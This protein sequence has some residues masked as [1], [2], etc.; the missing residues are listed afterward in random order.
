MAE[1]IK[2]STNPKK[3]KLWILTELYYPENN[4][5]GY[6]MTRIGEGLTKNFDVKV[7][8]GQPNYAF[9]GTI[10]PKNENH[11]DVEIF[12]V[13]GTTL[14]KNVL[15]FRLIN[16]ITHGWSVFFNA[17]FKIKKSDEVLTVSAPPSL[18]FL[19]A[20]AAKIKS[21]E[22]SVIIHDKYPE[23]LIA[24]KKTKPDS[25]FIKFFNRLNRWLYSNAKKIIVVGRDMEDI[26]R[27]QLKETV[28]P[29]N[30][31]AV[32][33]NWAALEE[34]EPRLKNENELLNKLGIADKF[35]FLYA[36]NMGHPQ[37]VESIIEC[38][39]KLKDHEDIRFIF[40]G[41]GVKRKW[42]EAEIEKNNLTNVFLL[43]PLPREK[44]TD[45]L[46]AC[47]V[48]FVSL[49]KKM[50]GVAMPSRTYNFLAAGKPILALTEKN[51][52]VERIISEENVGWTVSPQD[53]EILLKTILEI[54]DGRENLAK[55]AESARKTAVLK[56]N[57]EN[58][59]EK[60]RLILSSASDNDLV[61]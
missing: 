9:R 40:I 33:P 31:I 53:P 49:V 42:V 15:L 43:N 35:I 36:G 17:L 39:G 59:I 8:C 46:N 57:A 18:P 50:Y 45:F 29:D 52:E 11:K 44:Q 19:S 16:M 22:Y 38:A 20:L 24:V 30:K 1:K 55:L 23:I 12:R 37:D 32:I 14:D 21:V 60:Y 26:V 47:D 56:C 13:R 3:K 10:A 34:I 51:S 6:Y 7:I 2:N 41:D 48:G 28:K 58:S 5:T 27:E 4:Q 61:K 25:L 54:Y